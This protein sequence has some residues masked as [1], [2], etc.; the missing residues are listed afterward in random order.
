[1]R[2]SI[3]ISF[4]LLF[5][6]LI[7]FYL[8]SKFMQSNNFSSRVED[9]LLVS[10]VQAQDTHTKN[11]EIATSR[12]NA[13][14]LAVEEISPAV[15][16]VNVMQVRERIY[17]SP[18]KTRD[19]LMREFFPEFF[20]DR[21]FVEEIKALGSGFLISEDGYILTNDHVVF[22]ASKVMITMVGGDSAEAEIIG[23]DFISDIALLKIKGKNLPFIKMGDSEKILLGEWAIAVGNPFGLFEISNYPTVT[24]GVISAKNRDFGKIGEHRQNMRI[25]PNMI[26]T[27]A[28][29]N[30]GN[31][32]GPLCNALGEAIGMNTFIYTGS[33][34]N[35]GSVGIGF[36][37][38]INRIK[39]IIS[40]LKQFR[41]VKRD[42]WIGIKV[43]DIAGILSGR[44]AY[45]NLDGTLVTHVELGSPADK[46]G[47]QLEDIIIGVEEKKVKNSENLSEIINMMDPIVGESIR[48]TVLRDKKEVEI[49]LNLISRQ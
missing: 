30:H 46:A 45:Q 41:R 1:M 44:A 48:F 33:R 11:N 16:S 19:P 27:D 34:I 49:T 9:S 28:S 3:Q 40:D 20:Q 18:F 14:T 17:E 32:G 36:A 47:I 38:P 31:S 7:G 37:V 2:R 23:S 21:R 26:Q 43:K 13:I 15:V 4:A 10:D 5:G 42:V 35:E 6:I 29:I 12:Q 24:V 8:Y 25:Y 22:N 39:S